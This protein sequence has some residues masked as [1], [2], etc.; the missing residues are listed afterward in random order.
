MSN[1]DP[2]EECQQSLTKAR[3]ELEPVKMPK[4]TKR[5]GCK[6]KTKK[7][8]QS[9][10]MRREYYVLGFGQGM[11]IIALV[12]VKTIQDICLRAMPVL[13]HQSG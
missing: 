8:I 3:N 4:M 11:D 12:S 6:T 7:D 10:K 9:Q 5:L 1:T 2:Q 13:V